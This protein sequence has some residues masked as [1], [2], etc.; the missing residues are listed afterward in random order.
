MSMLKYFFEAG[1]DVM[2]FD[3]GTLFEELEISKEKELCKEYM[4]K[5][6]VISITPE[7]VNLMSNIATRST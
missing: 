3:N 5:F 7:S 6:P 2:L 1:S 4:G